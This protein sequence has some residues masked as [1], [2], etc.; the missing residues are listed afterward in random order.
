MEENKESLITLDT[1]LEDIEKRILEEND[2]DKL[3]NV[4]DIFNLNIQKKNIIRNSKL[5]EL[6]DLITAQMQERVAQKADE[7]SNQDLITYFKTV[8][9]TLNKSDN[10][11][12]SVNIPAIK[13]VQNQLNINVQKDALPRESKEKVLEVVGAILRKAAQGELQEEPEIID[14][15]FTD[16]CEEDETYDFEI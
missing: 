9:E 4:I 8:Q 16:E 6:Q 12:D 2:V 3:K 1:P 10:S 11:L 5:V 13:V 14:A 15:D 7:F